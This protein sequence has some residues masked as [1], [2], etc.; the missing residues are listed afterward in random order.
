MAIDTIGK[1]RNLTRIKYITQNVIII[2]FLGYSRIFTYSRSLNSVWENQESF[3]GLLNNC[4]K[5][6]NE[7]K[8]IIYSHLRDKDVTIRDLYLVLY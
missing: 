6:V 4:N 1:V 2:S 8:T 5:I 7:L 3:K